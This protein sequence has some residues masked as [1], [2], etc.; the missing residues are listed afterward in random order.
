MT[1]TAT[2]NAN[3]AIA[4]AAARV[5]TSLLSLHLPCAL[6]CCSLAVD[7]PGC[8]TVAA[9]MAAPSRFYEE[10]MRR[11]AYHRV[12]SAIWDSRVAKLCN[13]ADYDEV[14]VREALEAGHPI[15][16]RIIDCHGKLRRIERMEP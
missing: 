1:G 16:F 8:V 4:L 3:S 6:A 5:D 13:D 14:A 9:P 12:Q 7:W 10:N 11:L 2:S 15:N